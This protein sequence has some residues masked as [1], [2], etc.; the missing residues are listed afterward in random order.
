VLAPLGRLAEQSLVDV[1]EAGGEAR[2][3]LLETVRQYGAALLRGSADEARTRARHAAW[4]AALVSRE[5]PRLWSVARR[6]ASA[7]IAAV[8]DDVRA[9][10]AWAAAPVAPGGH[11]AAERAASEPD[12]AGRATQALTIAGGLTWFYMATGRWEDARRAYADALGAAEAAGLT[13]APTPDLAATCYLGAV[14]A[15]L[16]SD[17][18]LAV[19]RSARAVALYTALAA[20]GHEPEAPPPEAA[21]V[22]A[23]RRAAQIGLGLALE[24]EAQARGVTGD[25]AGAVALIDAA[26]ASAEHAG[27]PRHL[28]AVRARRGFI[29][30]AVGEGAGAEADFTAAVA[31]YQRVGE[32]WL[33]SLAYQGMAAHA[34]LLG[35]VGA[36]VARAA[37]SVAA[38]R[39]EDDPWFLSRS[40]DTLG[41]ALVASAAADGAPEVPC[42]ARTE[43]AATLLAA[44]EGRTPARGRAH[45]RVRPHRAGGGR[46]RRARRTRRRRVRRRLAGRRGARAHRGV[47]ARGRLPGRS[48]PARATRTPSAR[49]ARR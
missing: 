1:R 49:S 8:Y 21:R 7:E 2:Y 28:G 15:W 5:A 16:D 36:A 23:R 29:R 45:Q 30:M 41:A 13:A 38:V 24:M 42:A 27:D 37:A 17:F 19:E 47:R 31:A 12:A 22:E 18:L 11:T 44:A 46:G 10:L 4:I 48:W 33:L 25:L 32:R 14:V 35:D 34:L 3:R 20:D 9:A 43:A 26:V 39:D 6:E 40:L